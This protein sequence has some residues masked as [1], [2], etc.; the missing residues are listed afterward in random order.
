MISKKFSKI[1]CAFSLK[2]ILTCSIVFRVKF[3]LKFF[4][5][6]YVYFIFKPF[7][8]YLFLCCVPIFLFEKL[9]FKINVQTIDI[10]KA[11]RLNLT[12]K[13]FRP[14]RNWI[15]SR[16][17]NSMHIIEKI[18]IHNVFLRMLQQNYHNSI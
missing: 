10:K 8:Q 1:L 2:A 14:R 17:N 13:V 9:L 5:N 3:Y 12:R 16:G 6:N 15:H 11:I 7:L 4:R 18:L